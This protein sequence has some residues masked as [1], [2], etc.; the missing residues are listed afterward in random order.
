MTALLD[1]V[2]ETLSALRARKPKG[3]VVVVIVTDGYE[4]ASRKWSRHA[5]AQLVRECEADEWEIVFLGANI[6]SFAEA[7]RMGIDLRKTANY[8]PQSASVRS[9]FDVVSRKTRAHRRNR[10]RKMDFADRERERIKPGEA[11][12][13][14]DRN[15]C[16]C[17]GFRRSRS[18]RE[19]YVH[20]PECER[21][22]ATPS[23][24][25]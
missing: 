25:R 19:E 22:A 1:A 3:N 8:D 4:N 15:P 13:N 14:S 17:G 24:T 20:A 21:G 16:A 6:D 7:R 23:F 2:G 18:G 9:A 11:T 10:N 5:V 12:G